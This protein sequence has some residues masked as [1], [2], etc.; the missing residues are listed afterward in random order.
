MGS[1]LEWRWQK[2]ELVNLKTDQKDLPS[3]NKRKNRVKRAHRASGVCGTCQSTSQQH[4]GRT[5]NQKS[6]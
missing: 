1:A 3:L 2:I 6:G 4:H 5:G